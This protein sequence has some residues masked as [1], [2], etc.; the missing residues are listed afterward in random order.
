MYIYKEAIKNIIYMIASVSFLVG[1]VVPMEEK[2]AGGSVGSGGLGLKRSE[3]QALEERPALKRG[4]NPMGSHVPEVDREEEDIVEG[5]GASL[6]A[7]PKINWPSGAGEKWKEAFTKGAEAWE[8]SV[9]EYLKEAGKFLAKYKAR[10]RKTKSIWELRPRRRMQGDSM[11]SEK[12][13]FNAG[14]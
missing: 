6:A 3:R 11:E 7:E 10:H 4:K 9:N 1:A 2:G 5:G 14:I 12:F 8:M 13:Q